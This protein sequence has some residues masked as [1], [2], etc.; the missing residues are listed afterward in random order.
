[1]EFYD[2]F[3]HF[4]PKTTG[5]LPVPFAQLPNLAMRARSFLV[6]RSEGQI[7]AIAESCNK[8]VYAFR[9][10]IISSSDKTYFDELTEG[11]DHFTYTH[12]EMGE[13]KEW[14]LLAAFALFRISDCLN[15][16]HRSLYHSGEAAIDAA[17]AI[18]IAE[19]RHT[20]PYILDSI[21]R[22][23]SELK[24]ELNK[25]RSTG[26]KN[27]SANYEP[28]RQEA[29]TLYMQKTW[30]SV[31]NASLEITPKVEQLGKVIGQPLTST[32]AQTTV[33]SWLRGIEQ[34][35]KAEGKT[36]IKEKKPSN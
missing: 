1:M 25:G 35:L 4:N 23:K 27:R 7:E 33:N 30:H 28:L 9:D 17:Q 6:N 31:R 8:I 36:Q 3:K 18:C 29:K 34:A 12:E 16:A 22:T 21:D 11:L 20:L 5:L 26:G 19:Q 32:Q 15:Y 10:Q 2:Q 13:I 14:E 24:I